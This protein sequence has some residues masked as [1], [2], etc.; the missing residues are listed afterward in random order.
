MTFYEAMNEVLDSRRYRHLQENENSLSESLLNWLDEQLRRMAENQTQ[1]TTARD[2]IEFELSSNIL[3]WIFGGLG[4]LLLVAAIIF[5]I[6]KI[7][8]ARKNRVISLEEIF[9]EIKGLTA[10]DLIRKSD[11]AYD[12][13]LAV[14][15]R[16]IAVLLLLTERQAIDIRPSFTN[17]IILQQIKQLAL[18]QNFKVVAE[19]FHIAWFGKKTI[20]DDKYQAFISSVDT[21]LVNGGGS[22]E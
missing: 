19:T 13:H 4:I 6:F 17:A 9:E 16:Y 1:T 2:P 12:R 18:K 8:K 10:I 21:F 3:T 14:R 22:N 11:E 5:V 7:I 20:D 15:Y